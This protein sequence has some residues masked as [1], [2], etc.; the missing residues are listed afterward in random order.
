MKKRAPAKHPNLNKQNSSV[1]KRILI[2]GGAIVLCLLT[3]GVWES[4][5]AANAHSFVEKATIGNQF[6][7]ESSRIA[8]QQSQND[9]V[10]NLAQEMVDDHTKCG[11]DLRKLVAEKNPDETQPTMQ[12]DATHQ[13]MLDKLKA[14]KGADFDKLYVK[15]QQKAH[16]EAISLYKGYA[17]DGD[18]P[19]LKA[20][21]AQTLP[22]LQQHQSDVN[23]V[24]KS[25]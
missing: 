13:K 20:F 11:E 12:M 25:I 1:A 2:A 21:A 8:L 9:D 19:D 6:E 4:A 15:D 18:N 7:I 14:T 3:G 5:R 23:G 16:K 22:T 17:N 10:K 24:A